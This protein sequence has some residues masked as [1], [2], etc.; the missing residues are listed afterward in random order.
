MH[1]DIVADLCAAE[2]IEYIV[3]LPCDRTKTLCSVLE[4]RFR[5]VTIAREEDGIGICSGIS[6]AGRRCLL[7]MQSSGLGN[8]LN[9]LMTL[10]HLY[11]LPLPILA[12]WRGIYNEKIPAQVPFNEKIPELLSLYGIPCTT[13]RSPADLSA[14]HAVITDTYAKQR[15][16]VALITPNVWVGEIGRAHV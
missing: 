16:H 1:E 6:L 4:E 12:S 14:L 2:G 7:A 9:A 8:S 5:Y 3:S 11:G 15:P 10:P 13:I